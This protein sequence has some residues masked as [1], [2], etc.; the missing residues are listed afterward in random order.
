MTA[1]LTESQR[2]IAWALRELTDE[3]G[4]P[5]SIRE[6]ADAVALSASTVAYHLQALERHGIVTHTPHRS[7][8][9]QVLL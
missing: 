4:Y 1:Y 8:S 7:R 5:P 3:A 6:I 9:Y 2:R